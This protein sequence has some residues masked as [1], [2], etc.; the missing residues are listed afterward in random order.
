MVPL[1]SPVGGVFRI[2]I[3]S[4]VTDPPPAAVCIDW[5][6]DDVD[7]VLIEE[8]ELLVVVVI[9][10]SS[11]AAVTCTISGAIK[12][13]SIDLRWTLVIRRLVGLQRKTY[14]QCTRE[15]KYRNLT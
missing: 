9:S 14:W 15:Q 12:T 7:V 11:V 13:V 10:S 4:L 8:L 3:W 1:E 5:V 2:S 6:P